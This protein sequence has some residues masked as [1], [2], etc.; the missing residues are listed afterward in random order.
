MGKYSDMLREPVASPTPGF[1]AGIP[2]NGLV[3][4]WDAGLGASYP[5]P[6]VTN[7]LTYSEQFDNAAW[8]KYFVAVTADA[9]AAP[10]GTLTAD[11]LTSSGDGIVD[12]NITL[13]S[14]VTYTYSLWIKRAG[15]ADVAL[16]LLAADY[17]GP[18]VLARQAITA[19]ADW[20]RVTMTFTTSTASSHS[21]RIGAESTFASGEA[22]YAW[23]AQLVAGSAA[24]RYLRTT[25]AAV[26]R[27]GSSQWI[28]L[29]ND[30]SGATV[31]SDYD[32]TI[33]GL[34]FNGTA[35]RRS[36]GECLQ[37]AGS[38]YAQLPAN[39][40]FANTLHKSGAAFSVLCFGYM[41]AGRFSL[42]NTGPGSST[43]TGVLF[44]YLS[45]TLRYY[46]S[47]GSVNTM[48]KS[49]PL[50]LSAGIHALGLSFFD[51]ASSFFYF[52][53]GCVSV[54]GANTWTGTYAASTASAALLPLQIGRQSTVSPDDAGQ[55]R[56]VQAMW[57]RA[58]TKTELDQAFDALRGRWSI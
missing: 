1:V 40:P 29:A 37:T 57:N 46:V 45:G 8:T 55:S 30:I 7:L 19:T 53:G 12:R 21:I 31:A 39:T 51:G 49:T 35:G 18:G 22:I 42:V 5:A 4:L 43:D 6:S 58:L 48:N 52:D 41:N 28:N 47:N 9:S 56:F 16:Q 14:G 20:R 11:L 27:G 17:A 23:G 15:G 3:A 25:S 32:L 33:S 34:T 24:S 44:D 2:Q 13:L 50:S 38:G 26:T 10:D 54:G 36:A